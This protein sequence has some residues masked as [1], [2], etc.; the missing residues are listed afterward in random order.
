[1]ALPALRTVRAVLP[2]TALQSLVSSSGVSG[3]RMGCCEGEQPV[4]REEGVGPALMVGLTSSNAGALLLL[5]QGGVRAPADEA[6][7]DHQ[8][9]PLSSL[10]AVDQRRHHALRPDRAFRPP[11]L[12]A[13]GVCP[14]SSLLRHFQDDVLTHSR[15]RS[16][17]F[18]PPFPRPG[19]TSR[20][21]RRRTG[22]G[23]MKALT[24]AALTPTGRSLRLLRLAVPTFR[25]QPRGLPAGRLIRCPQRRRF[26]QAS[27]RM[28]RL[29]TAS[30][31]IRFVIL[32]TAS[33]PTVASHPASRRR[34]YLQLRSL[35]Q[36]PA[37]T[38]TALSRRP[39]GRT[40]PGE[41]RDPPCR[42]A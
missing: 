39:H 16:S 20:A 12:P 23:T 3:L 31:R 37:R 34:S 24:P 28:S 22:S 41:G 26:L 40:H 38:H 4:S 1:M 27:P 9:V 21:S 11:P 19:F 15:P 25:P 6:L 18:L 13:P 36:A 35:Q 8:A 42:I 14:R 33:S 5:E 10:D 32:R 2:H 30:R 7:V 29:A 17:S